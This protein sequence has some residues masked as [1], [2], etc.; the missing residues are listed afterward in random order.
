[1]SCCGYWLDLS[2]ALGRATGRELLMDMGAHADR[3]HM[4]IRDRD[5]KFTA[6]FDHVFPAEASE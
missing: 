4:L 3:F 5:A 1:M 2:P 6:A